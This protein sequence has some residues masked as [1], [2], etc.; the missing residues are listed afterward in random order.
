LRAQFGAPA[1][2]RRDNGAEI[3]R[4]DGPDC[5][6]FF[7]LYAEASGQAVRHV[8]TLPRGATMAADDACLAAIRAKLPSSPAAF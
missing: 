7:F 6:A 4:Y 5:R 3:W 2:V 8:E 1:F